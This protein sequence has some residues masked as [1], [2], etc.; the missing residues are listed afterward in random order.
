MLTPVTPPCYL[1]INQSEN[2]ARADHIP[3]NALPHLAFKNALL[4]PLRES[5]GLEHEPPVLL[6]LVTAI[7]A[8]LL[9]TTTQCQ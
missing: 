4:K 3:W 5:G 1:T 8:A 9:F 7:N 2:C 6:V